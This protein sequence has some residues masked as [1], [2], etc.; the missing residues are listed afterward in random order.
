MNPSVSGADYIARHHINICHFGACKVFR[1][2]YLP[3]Y[4]LKFFRHNELFT[5]PGF[6]NYFYIL[7][8]K[9]NCFFCLSFQQEM[10]HLFFQRLSCKEVHLCPHFCPPASVHSHATALIC[11][12]QCFHPVFQ[13]V[14]MILS[15]RI[16]RHLSGITSA[17]TIHLYIGT[18]GKLRG[19]LV[20]I[21][22][23]NSTL[24][25]CICVFFLPYH[26]QIGIGKYR[27]QPILNNLVKGF[28]LIKHQIAFPVK[29]AQIIP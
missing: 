28:G 23:K 6:L 16:A 26:N 17:C 25:I 15:L 4:F 10:I 21:L 27:K 5:A 29:I 19:T 2:Q 14:N 11:I 3:K 9:C 22:G 12:I 7:H 24:H 1:K 8:Q 18:D 20:G 13:T